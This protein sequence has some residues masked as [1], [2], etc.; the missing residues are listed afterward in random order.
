M[1]GSVT[2]IAKANLMRS[3]FTLLLTATVLLHATLGCCLHHVH[4]EDSGCHEGHSA[5]DHATVCEHHAQANAAPTAT[6]SEGQCVQRL[7]APLG[8]DGCDEGKCSFA[9]TEVSPD[10]EL[11]NAANL[12]AMFT[13]SICCLLQLPQIAD[14]SH[15][16]SCN[17]LSGD[18]RLHLA[19]A[20]LLI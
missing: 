2:L 4:A 13:I 6:V 12:P 10:P 15:A 19:F 3:L 20:V 8:H 17:V 5:A 11:A 9:R 18:L 16:S 1:R 14:R 7:P